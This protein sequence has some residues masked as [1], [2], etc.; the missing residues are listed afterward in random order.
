ML[1]HV[2]GKCEYKELVNITF[3]SRVHA[4]LYGTWHRVT[5][6]EFLYVLDTPVL[7]MQEN[8]AFLE[9]NFQAPEESSM[10]SCQQFEFSLAKELHKDDL[11]QLAT[12]FMDCDDV[13]RQSGEIME[14][15]QAI[16]NV[17]FAKPSSHLFSLEHKLWKDDC[18]KIL[19]NLQIQALQ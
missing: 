5:S 16:V 17:E 8:K 12:P 6:K 9:K 14:K 1:T 3:K 2:K 19:L 4:K 15:L 11:S 13:M 7:V 18:L 10:D